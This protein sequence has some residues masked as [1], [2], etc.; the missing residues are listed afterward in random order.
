M[1]SGVATMNS[2]VQGS[3]K[4]AAKLNNLNEKQLFSVLNN[5]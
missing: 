5:F 3:A 1:A 4:D 2:R